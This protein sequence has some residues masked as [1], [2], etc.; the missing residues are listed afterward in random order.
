MAVCDRTEALKTI[1]HADLAAAF[2]TVCG[3]RA[4]LA[5]W[6]RM[7]PHTEIDEECCWD[8]AVQPLPSSAALAI[9]DILDRTHAQLHELHDDLFT[10]VVG[11]SLLV[12][13]ALSLLRGLDEVDG[14]WSLT[15]EQGI[16]ILFLVDQ[17]MCRLD[18]APRRARRAVREMAEFAQCVDPTGSPAR[19]H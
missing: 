19:A 16:A 18:A 7:E 3:A 13:G 15:Q 8:E 4:L 12:K 6:L 10:H 9:A 5:A 1:D 2:V 14:D 17:V 11:E